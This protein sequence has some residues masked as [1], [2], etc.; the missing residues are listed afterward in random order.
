MNMSSGDPDDTFFV[1]GSGFAPQAS[2]TVSLD[3]QS[4]PQLNQ[5]FHRTSAVKPVVGPNGT[6]RF[7]VN[8]L[9]PGLLPL[10]QYNVVV[11]APDG[12]KSSTQFVVLPETVSPT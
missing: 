6:F 1:Q 8:Q 3:W 9:N 5:S 12:H 10:G 11:A 2:V 4:P 7:T